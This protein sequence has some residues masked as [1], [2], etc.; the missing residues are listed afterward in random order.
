MSNKIIANIDTPD[1]WIIA[2]NGRFYFTFTLDNRIEIWSSPTVEHFHNPQKSTVW[3]PAPGTPWSVN[4]WAPELHYL[5][6]RW[7]IYTCGAPRGVGNPGHRTTLL[8]CSSQ[9]PMD[10][11]AWEFLGPL[12]GMPDHWSID[13]TVFSPNTRDLYC[14]WSGWPVGD[15][16][17]TE[18][19]LFLIKMADPEHA[20]RD[21]L[22]CISR[23][24]L[25][26]ERPDDGRRG[27]NE[28]PSWVDIP[29]VFRG[30]VYS[31][32]GSWTSHYKLGLLPL[33][34]QDPLNPASWAKRSTPLLKSHKRCGGPYGPG[35]ASFLPNPR[36]RSR[37]YCVYH[38]TAGYGEGWANRKARVIDMGPECFAPNAHPLCCALENHIPKHH[39][40]DKSGSCVMS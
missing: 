31:A 40:R 22:V 27:V 33:V 10:A 5:N 24:E 19:D 37:V 39:K 7:Y 21:T 15:H 18:Q 25:E 34:G 1:P 3:H 38:A 17:D 16:S 11:S 23:A 12:K 13:A 30:I 2:G 35:H 20:I 32:D 4:I 8:R 9:D 29:G 6:G 28:G 26:W 14:C 36:D